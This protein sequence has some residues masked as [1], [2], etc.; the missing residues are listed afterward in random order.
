MEKSEFINAIYEYFSARK[1]YSDLKESKSAQ[2]KSILVQKTHFYLIFFFY[3]YCETQKSALLV[4]RQGENV[5]EAPSQITEACWK[6]LSGRSFDSNLCES[7]L[8]GIFLLNPKAP[9]TLL[10]EFLSARHKAD[11]SILEN[12]NESVS[13][14]LKNL[15]SSICL[16]LY[17]S[18][19]LFCSQSKQHH[20]QHHKET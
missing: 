7:A 1:S 13:Q 11:I 2:V 3:T 6:S 19:R 17:L 20:Q 8:C 10:K 18:D 14:N 12:T 5:A 9:E 4:E 16:T 15:I